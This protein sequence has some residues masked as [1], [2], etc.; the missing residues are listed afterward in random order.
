MFKIWA[1]Y[2]SKVGAAFTE[3]KHDK[4]IGA[5]NRKRLR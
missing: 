5:E 1:L 2:L 3:E 4:K